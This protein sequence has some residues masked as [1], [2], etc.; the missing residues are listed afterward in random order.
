MADAPQ[1]DAPQAD[2]PQQAN[3]QPRKKRRTDTAWGESI[4]AP[5]DLTAPDR[6]ILMREAQAAAEKA[7]AEKAERKRVRSARR[8]LVRLNGGKPLPTPYALFKKG[9]V[10]YVL[11]IIYI[12]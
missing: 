11:C 8:E 6:L 2:A 7:D 1:A 3:A 12:Y 4:S 5:L 10:F 9:M